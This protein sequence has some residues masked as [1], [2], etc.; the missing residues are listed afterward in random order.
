MCTCVPQTEEKAALQDSV[1]SDVVKELL[2]LIDNF[3]LA[4][5]NVKAETEQE[6]KINNSYQVIG[7][8]L[9][10]VTLCPAM[11]AAFLQAAMAA[12]GYLSYACTMP[13][14]G[15]VRQRSTLQLAHQR[16][17]ARHSLTFT[18]FPPHHTTSTQHAC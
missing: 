2:P 9:D 12:C 7:G 15:A 17:S 8:A 18:D 1:K 13:T 10:S 6:L 16:S 11:S 14:S 3:E 5:T 4:R